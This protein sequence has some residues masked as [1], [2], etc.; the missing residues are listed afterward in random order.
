MTNAITL[1]A[2][3]LT[4]LFPFALSIGI[5]IIVSPGLN[6]SSNPNVTAHLS[7]CT[8]LTYAYA[9]NIPCY[10]KLQESAY[11]E[12]FNLTL[13]ELCAPDELWSTCLLR[14]VYMAPGVN[15]TMV[16]NTTSKCTPFDCATLT[17]TACPQPQSSNF[18]NITVDEAQQWYGGW[19]IYSL[20]T[21]MK[22][23][24]LALN[25]TSSES[26]ILSVI[27]P[28]IASTAA[29]VLGALIS[30]YGVNPNADSALVDLIQVPS[31]SP[32]PLYG[33]RNLDAKGQVSRHEPSGT[34]WRQIL[35][36]KMQSVAN[37]AMG[38]FTDF[39]AT[40]QEGAFATR[41]LANATVLAER[42]AQNDTGEGL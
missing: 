1:S 35:V 30:K 7:S 41:G 11:L 18:T 5:P 16:T 42:M 12:N 26:A 8:N 20:H 24:A 25:A 33:G 34:E 6:V 27:N 15:C 29:I 28:R 4:T 21:F 10:T 22:S 19:N 32:Q 37:D 36:A 13:A 23:W 17:S 31:A 9:P 38:N 2:F 3:V 40:V 39:L 14:A